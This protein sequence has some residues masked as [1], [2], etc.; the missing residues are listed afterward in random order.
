MMFFSELTEEHIRINRDLERISDALH[1]ETAERVRRFHGSMRWKKANGSEYLF[2]ISG[3]TRKGLGRRSPETEKIYNAFVEGKQRAQEQVKS[4]SASLKTTIGFAK[5]AGLGRVPAL[6][7][8]ILRRLDENELLGYIK[9]VG[10][11]A[12]FAYEAIADIRFS[13]DIIATSGIDFL[14]DARRRS[15]RRTMSEFMK[16]IDPSFRP[17]PGKTY[18]MVNQGGFFANL[19]ERTPIAAWQ[20]PKDIADPD[21]IEGLEW[22]AESKSIRTLIVDVNGVPAPIIVPDPRIWMLHKMWL[23]E[24]PTRE[25]S[26]AVRDRYQADALFDL[27]GRYLPNHPID[28][29]FRQNLP[30]GL[31]PHA[32]KAM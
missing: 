11:V 5:A 21:E 16:G 27:F 17:V 20:K 22:L 19:I 30:A 29:E 9:I 2:R 32:A 6:T 28:Q 8:T 13:N 1:R 15:S 31:R 23:S 25:S 7:A 26:R 18:C 24:R 4:L 3:A 12:L 14:V 10:T